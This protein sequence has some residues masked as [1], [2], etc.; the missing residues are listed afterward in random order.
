MTGKTKLG[1]DSNVNA[2]LCYLPL[3]CIPLLVAIVTVVMEKENRFAR[4]HA[5]Q[6]LLVWG[7]AI[8]VTVA[9]Q[10]GTIILSMISG[11]LGSLFSLLMLLVA[12]A[13]LGLSIL[14]SVKAY[15]NEEYELPVIGAMAKKWASQ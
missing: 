12:L 2:L 8:V 4:F 14:L 1:L 6:G 5:F 11:A 13:L 9:L 10:V 3:C 15:N 7:V